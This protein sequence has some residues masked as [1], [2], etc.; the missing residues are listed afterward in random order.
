M[1]NKFDTK[2]EGTIDMPL[3]LKDHVEG[4]R[5]LS[6][7]ELTG[8]PIEDEKE[9]VDPLSQLH[10]LDDIA[11]YIKETK[12][13]EVK[14]GY[15]DMAK[16]PF[17]RKTNDR[18][19]SKKQAVRETIEF[20]LDKMG[21]G[22]DMQEQLKLAKQLYRYAET[23]V[24]DYKNKKGSYEDALGKINDARANIEKINDKSTE[25]MLNYLNNWKE[26]ITLLFNERS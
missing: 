3:K 24:S 11:N 7:K 10:T 12:G 4:I 22:E 16:G 13:I 14:Q 18:N 8:G 26:E 9:K 5:D 1:E 20:I 17:E 19:Y 15:I 21:L 25:M 6:E 23:S 2:P